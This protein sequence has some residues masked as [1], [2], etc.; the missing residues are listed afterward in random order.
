MLL[1]RA[2]RYGYAL[3]VSIALAGPAV[4]QE[5]QE[6]FRKFYVMVYGGVATPTGSVE[7][8]GGLITF[9]S[10]SAGDIYETGVAI[11]VIVGGEQDGWLAELAFETRDPM[12]LTDVGQQV[13]NL[14]RT[15]GK[16][17][18]AGYFSIGL[19]VAKGFRL[20]ERVRPFLGLSGGLADNQLRANDEAPHDDEGFAL[21][22]RGG[23]DFLPKA[24]W[25]LMLRLG[26]KYEIFSLGPN[27]PHDV[28]YHLGIG[29]GFEL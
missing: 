19:F 7:D 23:I 1:L 14:S 21:A 2:S 4:A 3:L 12:P 11:G 25:A 5:S 27:I 28:S 8:V 20:G 18:D 29:W 13:A 16:E 15:D 17:V 9:P 6:T 24:S 26:A 10:T 22:A